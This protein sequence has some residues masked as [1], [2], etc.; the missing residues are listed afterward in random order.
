MSWQIAVV[1]TG[2]LSGLGQVMGKR[3]VMNLGAF[4]GG[5]IRDVT[6]LTLI[7]GVLLAEG[8]I[9]TTFAW[10]MLLIFVFGL[11][12]SVSMALY[13]SA[14]R[15]Q[16]A[17]TAV[18]SYPLSQLLII[19]FSSIF[20]AEWRYFDITT[21][22]GVFNVVALVLTLILLVLYQGGIGK[23]KG[24][25]KWSNAL[26]FSAVI[27]ALTNIESKWAVTTL[28]Y[29]PAQSM[30]YE[31]IGMIVGGL[32]Y[33]LYNRQSLL[34][35]WRN[36]GVGVLQG[37]LFGVSAIWYVTLLVDNPVGIA[38]LLRRVMIVLVALLAGLW[39]YGERKALTKHQ[40]MSLGLGLI[41]FA[42]VM[43]VN[44]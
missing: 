34:V 33:V 42:L 29:S 3:L 10:P 19:L 11:L 5:V 9:P 17:A 18:F 35:G 15:S 26:A 23:L 32:A 2:V 28:Q 21:L 4:Q 1:L 8:G 7:L 25:I 27:V 44:R 40:M 38:S 39:G 13:F 36:L 12:E 16:M 43:G 24:K 20:F 14:I 6:T 30:F 31:Y 41:V 37:L 22:Q